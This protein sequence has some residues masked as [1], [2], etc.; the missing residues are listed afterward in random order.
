LQSVIDQSE[1]FLLNSTVFS[2]SAKLA[3]ADRYRLVLLQNHCLIALDSVD[4]ITALTE[5]EEY[6]KL[7]DTTKAALLEKTMQL[8]KEESA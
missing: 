8:L 2:I 7:S 5:T 6:K 4:K 1:G 3:L